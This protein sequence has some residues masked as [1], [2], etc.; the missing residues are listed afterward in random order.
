LYFVWWRNNCISNSANLKSLSN[1]SS[2]DPTENDGPIVTC[3]SFGRKRRRDEDSAQLTPTSIHSWHKAEFSNRIQEITRQIQ[4]VQ[5]DVRDTLKLR[6]SSFDTSSSH[7]RSTSKDDVCPTSS[8]NQQKIYGRDSEKNTI[9]KT[10]TAEKH[11]SISVLSIVGIGGVGK[12]A[13]TQLIY[14]DPLVKEQ[15]ERI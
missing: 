13:L 9:I 1:C 5:E 7:C 10:I 14:N 3:D 2:S 4:D 11:E 8:F 12:T 15:F 6:G